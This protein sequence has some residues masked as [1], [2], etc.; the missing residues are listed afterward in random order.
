MKKVYKSEIIDFGPKLAIDE[1]IT[2]GDQVSHR[3]TEG[4]RT[5]WFQIAMD[6]RWIDLVKVPKT[7]C[8]I[9][10]LNSVNSVTER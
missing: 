5:H 6:D 7:E 10:E 1:D 3:Y 8:H 4:S 9:V 2:L